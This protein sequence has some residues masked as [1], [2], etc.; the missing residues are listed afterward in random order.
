MDIDLIGLDK[1]RSLEAALDITL[2]PQ[3][4]KDIAAATNSYGANIIPAAERARALVVTTDSIPPAFEDYFNDGWYE[5]EWRLR[6]LPL[7][8]RNGTACDQQ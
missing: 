1:D 7:L 2:W 3:I 6:A 4:L 8:A 5:N